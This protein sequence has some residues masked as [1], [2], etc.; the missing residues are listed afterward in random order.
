MN[1]LSMALHHGEAGDPEL[2]KWIK[3]RLDEMLGLDP[4]IVAA[5]LALVVVAIPAA[6]LLLY[7]WKQR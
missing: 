4:T 3:Q 6:I 1:P 7:G 5:L 2:F